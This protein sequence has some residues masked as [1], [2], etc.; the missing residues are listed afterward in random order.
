MRFGASG[1]TQLTRLRVPDSEDDLGQPLQL[2][3]ADQIMTSDG[4]K[5]K[6]QSQAE[7][8]R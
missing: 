8:L 6:P 1:S 7:N 4:A 3:A 2:M 5:L